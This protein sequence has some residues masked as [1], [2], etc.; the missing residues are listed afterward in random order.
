MPIYVY[1]VTRADH[2]LRLE[3]L[4]GVG[5]PPSEL[6]YLATKELAAVVGDA[7]PELRAKR[8]DLMAHQLV[9]ERLMADGAALPMRFGLLGPDDDAVLGVLEEQRDAYRRRL[10]EL[11]GCLEYNLKVARDERD[12]LH[13]ILTGSPEAR[14]LDAYTREH[15]EAQGDKVALGELLMQEAQQ[16]ERTEAEGLVDRLA[17]SA[18]RTAAADPT[19][20]HFLNVSFLVE[21]DRATALS[22]AVHQEAERCGDSYDFTLSGPLPPYSFV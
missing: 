1:A 8:R 7:P 10:E 16:R 18:L 4:Q 13:E 9:L 2:P 19:A 14:R 11:D 3:G 15:P 22:E 5:D 6:R 12:L 17:P 21:R 20:A